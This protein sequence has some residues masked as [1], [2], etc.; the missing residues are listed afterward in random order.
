MALWPEALKELGGLVASGRLKYR[1]TVA[2]GIE[3]APEAFLGQIRANNQTDRDL[4]L[5]FHLPFCY[6]LCW[7]CG[8][9]TV[10]TTQQGQSASYLD[11]LRKELALLMPMLHRDR[12]VVQLHFGGGSPT[13]LRPDEIRRLGEIIHHEQDQVVFIDLG[14]TE[15][16][17]V[18]EIE[19]IGCPMDVIGREPMVV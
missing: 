19:A 7:Y 1:E 6:S 10:I 8:C 17:E 5:Y 18:K 13:F 9:T 2:F 12:R 11:H 15:G 16:R 14:P 4:S 3:N